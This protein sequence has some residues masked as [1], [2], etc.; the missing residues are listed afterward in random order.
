MIGPPSS[1]ELLHVAILYR[2]CLSD[3]WCVY[4]GGQDVRGADKVPL[5]DTA[6]LG[7]GLQRHGNERVGGRA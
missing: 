7:P 5:R 6:Q 3:P 1:E 4:L 2:G